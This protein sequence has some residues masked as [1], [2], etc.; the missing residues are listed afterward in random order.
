MGY[1]NTVEIPEDI[2]PTEF[3]TV[4]DAVRNVENTD[5]NNYV[6]SAGL[7]LANVNR[8]YFRMV[9]TDDCTVYLGDEDVTSQLIKDGETY[10]YYTDGLSIT[11]NTKVHVLTIKNAE[12]E[13]IS[14]V[15]YNVNAYIQKNCNQESALGNLVRAL[16]N[17][18]ESARTYNN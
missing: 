3:T 11:E 9:L 5:S 1:E 15:E 16:Y 8:I 18:S 2:T 12:G 7:R 17:A 13:T 4:T 14:T 10:L 6:K